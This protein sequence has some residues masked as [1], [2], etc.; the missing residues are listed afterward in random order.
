MRGQDGE[1]GVLWYNSILGFF[2]VKPKDNLDE[3]IMF[4]RYSLVYVY[5]EPKFIISQM[6][7]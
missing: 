4:V 1:E 2:I 7:A 5:L 3:K 6:H